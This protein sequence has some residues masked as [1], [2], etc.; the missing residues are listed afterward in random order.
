M[1]RTRRHA[2]CLSETSAQFRNHT[3]MHFS[4]KFHSQIRFESETIAGRDSMGF[5][6]C[7]LFSADTPEVKRR[8]FGTVSQR[9]AHPSYSADGEVS[10]EREVQAIQT[11]MVPSAKV[12]SSLSLESAAF[13]EHVPTRD[14]KPLQ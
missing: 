7:P 2:R 9:R 13:F 3:D 10:Y 4:R 6:Q 12:F 14:Q 11:E 1:T 8:Y 5:A